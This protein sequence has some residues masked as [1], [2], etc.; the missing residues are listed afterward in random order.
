[1]FEIKHLSTNLHLEAKAKTIAVIYV[2]ALARCH[3][4]TGKATTLTMSK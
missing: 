3:Y 4:V 2:T 1:M